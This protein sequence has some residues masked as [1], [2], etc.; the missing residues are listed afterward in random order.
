MCTNDDEVHSYQYT[1][2]IGKSPNNSGCRLSLEMSGLKSLVVRKKLVFVLL[3]AIGILLAFVACTKA[4]TLRNLTEEEKA[5]AIQIALNTSEAQAQL[6]QGITYKS[7]LNWVAI[8]W[9][10]SRASEIYGFDY[11]AW[12]TGAPSNIPRSA[13]IYSRVSLTFGE[14]ERLLVEVA[15]DLAT[16]KAVWVQSH[17]LK[18]L[19]STF[20][21]IFKYGVGAKNEL[22]TFDGTY[23]R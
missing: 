1:E 6:E 3:L 2:L 8:V 5:R 20:N 15:V 11:D 10:F 23:T 4:S 13:V 16:A 21:L 9:R 17:P 22:N 12:E 7:D 14:P 19:P 18:S